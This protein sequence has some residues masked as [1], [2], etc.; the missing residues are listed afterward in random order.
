PRLL[1]KRSTKP[2]TI[3]SVITCG[4]NWRLLE[5][6]P[7]L[8]HKRKSCL[9]WNEDGAIDDPSDG[10]GLLENV[11][12]ENAGYIPTAR[13]HAFFAADAP[14]ATEN[15]KIHSQHTIIA[16]DNMEGWAKQ[17][18]TLA[19]ELQKMPF[20]AEMETIIVKMR[21][22]SNQILLGV[23][24]NGNELIEPIPGEGGANT[25]YEHAYYMAE[26]P[27]LLGANRIPAPAVENP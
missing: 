8:L 15:I 7:F 26:M 12:E 4:L 2:K 16:I 13:S 25:A 3:C 18:L 22:L 23:D 24:S 10:F 9:D 20:D 14:D 5:F 6:T 1:E 21:V 17:L 27:L 11:N 19:L